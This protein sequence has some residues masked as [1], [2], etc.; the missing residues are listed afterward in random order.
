MLWVN[1]YFTVQSSSMINIFHINYDYR[2]HNISI[3][4]NRKR[5]IVIL[6]IKCKNH[7]HKMTHWTII[8]NYLTI[9][10]NLFLSYSPFLDFLFP[11]SINALLFNLTTTNV[12]KH[13]ISKI[14]IYP[15]SYFYIFASIVTHL[16]ADY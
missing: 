4:L 11:I 7:W 6:G 2:I 12:H 13:Q 16:H 5:L 8:K 15:F 14:T 3:S 9:Y 10:D 1:N